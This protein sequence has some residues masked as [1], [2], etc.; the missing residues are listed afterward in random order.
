M[1]DLPMADNTLRA[2]IRLTHIAYL[3]HAIGAITL[4]WAW[5]I[6]ALLNYIK[7]DDVRGTFLDSHFTWQIRTFWWGLVWYIVGWL[8]FFGTFGIGF[9]IYI[10]VW[11][12]G[13]IWVAYRIIKGWL[14]LND[15]KPINLG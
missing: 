4:G 10:P 12:I 6:G 5:I 9:F 14:A 7:R 13:F 2:N 3:F 1:S 15:E 11:F 8:A